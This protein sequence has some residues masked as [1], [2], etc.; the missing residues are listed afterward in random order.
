MNELN[1]WSRD[2]DIDFTLKV[3]FSGPVKLTKNTDFDN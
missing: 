1:A 3:Y 2:L